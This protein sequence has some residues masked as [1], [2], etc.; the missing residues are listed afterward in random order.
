MPWDDVELV[1]G[2]QKYHHVVDHVVDLIAQKESDRMDNL[3]G[4][5]IDIDLE[6][7]VGRADA[8]ER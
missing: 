5:I 6:E 1:A 7:V 8:T 4:P 3:R 2:T